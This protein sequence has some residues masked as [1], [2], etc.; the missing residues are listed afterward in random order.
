MGDISNNQYVFISDFPDDFPLW[1]G[2]A[3]KV[4]ITYLNEAGK[5]KK[6]VSKSS[7]QI[8]IDVGGRI[9]V[10]DAMMYPAIFR[11]ARHNLYFDITVTLPLYK[12]TGEPQCSMASTP[13]GRAE[14]SISDAEMRI[15]GDLVGCFDTVTTLEYVVRPRKKEKPELLLEFHQG[16]EPDEKES[17]RC[18]R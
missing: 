18:L 6:I 5:R 11:I 4:I 2:G 17:N 16:L 1:A 13:V 9:V 8:K 14:Y 7:A 10:S 12:Y 3:G 15:V